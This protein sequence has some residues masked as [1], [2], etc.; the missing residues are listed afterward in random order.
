MVL[1]AAR[2]ARAAVASPIIPE[3]VYEPKEPATSTKP[4]QYSI[5]RLDSEQSVERKKRLT[6]T[7][8]VHPITTARKTT[9]TV[10]IVPRAAFIPSARFSATPN[11]MLT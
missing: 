2:G 11:R 3:V 7:K 9:I 1:G 8:P 4:R 6:A 5:H 10:F